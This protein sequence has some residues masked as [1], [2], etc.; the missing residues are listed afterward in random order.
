M[1]RR[2]DLPFSMDGHLDRFFG[3]CALAPAVAIG[4]YLAIQLARVGHSG[5]ECEG[6]D[7]HGRRL[8]LVP[9]AWRILALIVLCEF[10]AGT[11]KSLTLESGVFVQPN[12]TLLDF[13][14]KAVVSGLLLF[15][16]G[17]VSGTVPQASPRVMRSGRSRTRSISVVW[18][19][20]GGL[21]ILTLSIGMISYLVLLAVEN[22]RL[23]LT[24]APRG[25]SLLTIR[26]GRALPSVL[27]A[28]L[29]AL[30]T[31]LWAVRDLRAES[32][33]APFSLRV[34]GAKLL[35]LGATL[36]SAWNLIGNTLPLINESFVQ[37]IRFVAAPSAA[38]PIIA[39]FAS[40]AAGI[41][42]RGISA[43]A[44]LATTADDDRVSR[45][46]LL[47][48]WVLRWLIVSSLVASIILS[49]VYSIEAW[50]GP[51]SGPFEALGSLTGPVFEL[52]R[53]IGQN[54]RVRGMPI[55]QDYTIYHG[56]IWIGILVWVS[57][58]TIRAI[59]RSAA[60]GSSPLDTVLMR[61]ALYGRFLWVWSA[62]TVVFLSA[63]PAFSIA[64]L[65]LIHYALNLFV[66]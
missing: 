58:G 62:L 30:V 11:T 35:L 54:V 29:V 40:L 2:V 38:W 52:L 49:L 22:V 24:H 20:L 5:Y 27:L 42:A 12:P 15:L 4:I 21:L 3:V 28:W 25:P 45:L 48:L 44:R 46:R 31:A 36:A 16:A 63:L 14:I 33:P 55:W 26:M 13:R 61:P 37:G 43:R 23:A 66:R 47:R 56:G 6:V 60:P 53:W 18:A 50:T 64:S 39:G 8:R 51:L 9:V 1:A 57:A 59:A 32:P 41:A 17:L 34:A 7:S 10:I 19:A 65:L